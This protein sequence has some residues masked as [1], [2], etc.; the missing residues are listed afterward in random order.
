MLEL[1][2]S[3]VVHVIVAVDVVTVSAMSEITG[4][5]V[6]ATTVTVALNVSSTA[7]V[8]K[9]NLPVMASV[10]RLIKNIERIIINTIIN[11]FLNSISSFLF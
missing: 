1:E 5:V 6:S 2:D 4:A 8:S 3:S 11:H 9:I 7:L 10:K